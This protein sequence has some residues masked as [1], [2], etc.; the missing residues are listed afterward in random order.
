MQEKEKKDREREKSSRNGKKEEKK[1]RKLWI[2][3]NPWT[4]P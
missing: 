4:L 3:H 1:P 2:P